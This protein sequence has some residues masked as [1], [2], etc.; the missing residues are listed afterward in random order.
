[1]SIRSSVTVSLVPEARGGP[2]VFWDDLAAACRKAQALGFDAIEVFPPSA[3][4]LDARAN[5]GRC[6]TTTAWLW[7]RWAPARAGSR[8]RLTSAS[9]NLPRA[10]RRATSSAR[11]S[12][13]PAPFGAPAIIGS[14]QG[15]SGD[16]VGPRHR[17]RLPHRRPR[18]PRRTRQQYGVPLVYRAAEPLRDE[19]GQHDRG[20]R[21]PPPVALDAGTSCC[22]PTSST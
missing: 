18:R 16:G 3:D 4:A 1:M 22:S 6:S 9:P 5:C 2:F 15:R 19:P 10:R 11:S 14:M 13:S 20:G 8:H 7:P 21:R 17:C 12:T